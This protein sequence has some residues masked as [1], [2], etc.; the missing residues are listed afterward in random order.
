[1]SPDWFESVVFDGTRYD[2]I[3]ESPVWVYPGSDGDDWSYIYDDDMP[4]ELRPAS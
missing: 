2:R 4:W 1:M 3:V